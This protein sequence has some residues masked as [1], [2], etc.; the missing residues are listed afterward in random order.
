MVETSCDIAGDA[1]DVVVGGLVDAR[2][3][4]VLGEGV[5]GRRIWRLWKW[6][7]SPMMRVKMP[8][9][10]SALMT[11]KVRFVT[12]TLRRACGAAHALAG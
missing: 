3:G 2:G 5:R 4:S 12:S 11:L 9:L 1:S 10:T 6:R 8:H 7:V